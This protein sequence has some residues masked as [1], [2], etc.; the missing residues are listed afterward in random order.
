MYS[1]IAGLPLFELSPTLKNILTEELDVLHEG[2]YGWKKLAKA[3]KIRGNALEYLEYLNYLNYSRRLESPTEKLLEI[4]NSIQPQATVGELLNIL[5]GSYVNRPDV[6]RL[7]RWK[8]Q[9]I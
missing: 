3:F 6:A 7:M 4:L 8:W 1:N 5:E 9:N 2:E